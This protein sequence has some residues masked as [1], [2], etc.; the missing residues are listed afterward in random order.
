M[1]L[2][3][4]VGGADVA[5]ALGVYGY[6]VTRQRGSHMRLT[7]R[8]ATGEHHITIPAHASLRVGTLA[9]IVREV[10]THLGTTRDEVL[11]DLDL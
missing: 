8:A 9:S 5:K 3:R 1:K 11:R 2:P 10:A 6:E 7:R 4:D